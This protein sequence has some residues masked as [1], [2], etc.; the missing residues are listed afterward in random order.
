MD[1][2]LRPFVD[3]LWELQEEDIHT[4]DAYTGQ[5]FRLHAALL[6]TINDFP[7]YNNLSRWTTIGKMACL[8]CTAKTDSHW[9]VYGHKHCYIGH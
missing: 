3:E 1:V 7:I 9:L 6:W 4:Y 8:T 2:F 5:M